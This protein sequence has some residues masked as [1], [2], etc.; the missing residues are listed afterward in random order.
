MRIIH[1]YDGHEKVF[2]GEGSV[3]SVVYYLAK[4][5]AKNVG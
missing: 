3:P 1:V 4:Y 5:A 2:P